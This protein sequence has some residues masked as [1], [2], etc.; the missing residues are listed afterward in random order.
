MNINY[1]Q[2]FLCRNCNVIEPG[3]CAHG[4]AYISAIE[5]DIELF[6]QSSI[7][8]PLDASC[9]RY[10][11]IHLM[12]HNRLIR[13]KV[14]SK[15]VLRN[16][17]GIVYVSNTGDICY[18]QLINILVFQ[19]AKTQ[20]G[21]AIILSLPYSSFKLCHDDVTHAMINDHIVSLQRPRLVIS[22]YYGTCDNS[23]TH[24]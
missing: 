3:Y 19:T 17:S 23:M 6:Q 9:S 11:L 5:E 22:V 20:Q 14:G 4:K 10:N 8:V 7:S 21:F 16:N 12:S 1:V 24:L 15:A 13:S 2:W 18:G